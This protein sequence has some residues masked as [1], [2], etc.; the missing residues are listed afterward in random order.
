MGNTKNHCILVSRGPLG[1]LT[2]DMGNAADAEDRAKGLAEAFDGR[3]G[4][5]FD[6]LWRVDGDAFF[7]SLLHRV[8]PVAMAV[9]DRVRAELTTERPR[10]KGLTVTHIAS[11]GDWEEG[12]DPD[13]IVGVHVGLPNGMVLSIQW[14]RFR[15]GFSGNYSNIAE[16]DWLPGKEPT[17]E[18]AAWQVDENGERGQWYRGDHYDDIRGHA[19]PDEVCSFARE[20]AE[21][22]PSDMRPTEDR[23]EAHG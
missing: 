9:V 5:D 20:V 8:R 3:M 14:G 22:D 2:I 16:G 1:S 21:L 19:T 18:I 10:V 15:E 7:S 6:G 4:Q 11:K 12:Y 13:E 17:F 23:T